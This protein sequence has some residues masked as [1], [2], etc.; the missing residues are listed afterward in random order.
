MKENLDRQ[1]TRQEL[2][3]GLYHLVR[4]IGHLHVLVIFCAFALRHPRWNCVRVAAQ[5][6]S[7]DGTLHN[8]LREGKF[9]M[10]LGIEL[11]C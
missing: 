3:V 4:Q 6:A 7:Q 9:R 11:P 1:P 10:R 5:T 8:T 2:S